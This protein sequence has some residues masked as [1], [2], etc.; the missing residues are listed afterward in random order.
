[1][2]QRMIEQEKA[3]RDLHFKQKYGEKEGSQASS[4][5]Q[6]RKTEDVK[7]LRPQP[8]GSPPAEAFDGSGDIFVPT[9]DDQYSQPLLQTIE[10][11]NLI[12]SFLKRTCSSEEEKQL[13]SILITKLIPDMDSL[14][15]ASIEHM[16]ALIQDGMVKYHASHEE[17]ADSSFVAGRAIELY[18][19]LKLKRG[20]IELMMKEACQA[21][22][23]K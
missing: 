18:V 16:L 4:G 15:F 19:K 13:C 2:L 7:T 1:M 14:D 9:D 22:S 21:L 20:N 5:F 10:R 3:E 6:R 12:M 11:Y 23:K 8:P 17:D